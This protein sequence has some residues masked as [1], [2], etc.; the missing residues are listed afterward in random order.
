AA[1]AEYFRLAGEHA[2]SLNA[3]V[4]ALVQFQTALA[5]GHLSSAL[6]HEQIG[7]LLTLTGAYGSALT[8]YQT[9]AAL[10]TPQHLPAI[11]HKIG[12]LYLRMG[13]WTLAEEHFSAALAGHTAADREGDMA[14]ALADRSLAAHRQGKTAEATDLAERARV[15][16]EHAQD[17]EAIAQTHNILGILASSSGDL[18][19]ALA[20]LNLSLEQ[21]DQMEDAGARVAALNNL[22]LV[23]RALH[24]IDQA[25]ALTDQ[26][27]ALCVRQGDRHRE[28]ALRNNLA[29]LLQES[30][31]VE[32][33]MAQL[34]QAVT[35]FA[36]IGADREAPEPEIW[37]LFEW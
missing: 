24:E 30:G 3:N 14:R 37:K 5:A 12:G 32:E 31:Q 25:R 13:A 26:A 34:K 29:D 11:E 21:A 15:L 6:L 36:E 10:A 17:R 1:A 27:L 4:E 19:G 23:R 28:A 2:R 33:S 22:A 20:H 8:S 16:A 7:E 9:A 18:G 35:I